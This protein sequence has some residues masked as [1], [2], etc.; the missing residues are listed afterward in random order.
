MFDKSAALL[1]ASYNLFVLAVASLPFHVTPARAIGLGA[2]IIYVSNASTPAIETV[3]SQGNASVFG[4]T[5]FYPPTALAVDHSG[6]VYAATGGS[7]IWS[8]VG[9]V[10]C[11]VL[12]PCESPIGSAAGCG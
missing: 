1:K 8:C 6:N 10:G 3:D 4:Y 5:G 2:D 7:V 9:V 12:A 11:R